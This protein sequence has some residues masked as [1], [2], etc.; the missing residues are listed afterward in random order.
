M[1]LEVYEHLFRIN[2]AFDQVAQSLSALQKHRRFHPGEL[3]RFLRLSKEHRAS[4]SSYL[5]A[6][7]ESAETDQA[8]RRFRRRLAEE[9]NDEAGK[10]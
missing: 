5:A 6:I 9:R 8:G 7:I 10:T 3:S 2:M 1:K 4:L